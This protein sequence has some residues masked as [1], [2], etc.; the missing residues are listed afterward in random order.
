LLSLPNVSQTVEALLEQGLLVEGEAGIEITP[1]GQ[2]VRAA[3]RFKPRE[4]LLSTLA[5]IISVKIEL[6][7]KDFFKSP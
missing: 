4:G 1:A 7:L 2:S 5:N 3:V 6:T